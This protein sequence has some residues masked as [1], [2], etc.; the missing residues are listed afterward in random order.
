M[1]LK[2]EGLILRQTDYKE[3]D[4]LLTVLT[5]DHGKMTLKAR[6]VRSKSSKLKSVCQ[7]LTYGEFTLLD[8]RG[9]HVIT[10]AEPKEM[11]FG[12]RGDL[13]RLSLGAYF[14]QAAEVVSQEDV[15]NPELLSLTLNALYALCQPARPKELIKA[16]FELRLACLA[17][18]EPNLERCAVCGSEEP[19]RF[20]VSNGGLQCQT[21]G[22]GYDGIRMPVSKGT[23]AA[24]RYI[25]YCPAKRLFSFTLSQPALEELCAVTETFLCTQLERGFYTLDFYKSLMVKGAG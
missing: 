1:Y 12:L 6:G 5:K 11:F 10:E 7:L 19:D 18:Y 25:V 23:L 16:A 2:T 20:N 4:R 8:Y 21:C 14:A 15:I 17:G 9:Y 13:E 3:R 22:E 24:M